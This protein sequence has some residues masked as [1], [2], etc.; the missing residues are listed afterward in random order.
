MLLA[1]DICTQGKY[2]GEKQTY[3]NGGV[4]KDDRSQGL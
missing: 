4:N 1:I 2:D 3:I